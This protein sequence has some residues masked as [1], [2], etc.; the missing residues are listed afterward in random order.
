MELEINIKLK[1]GDG[2]SAPETT[3]SNYNLSMEISDGKA[4]NEV[5]LAV[6]KSLEGKGIKP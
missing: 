1:K 6:I 3:I 2:E 5:V 4:Y